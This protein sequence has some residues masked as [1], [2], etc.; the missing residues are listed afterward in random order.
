MRPGARRHL[1]GHAAARGT[2]HLGRGRRYAH[3]GSTAAG[4]AAARGG[5]TR[6]AAA[7]RPVKPIP[8]DARWREAGGSESIAKPD[9]AGLGVTKL[10][11]SDLVSRNHDLAALVVG[12]REDAPVGEGGSERALDLLG[13]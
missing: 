7:R 12:Q 10:D 6:I 13:G 8:E 4:P 3:C 1:A 11:V 5:V 2:A 9:A